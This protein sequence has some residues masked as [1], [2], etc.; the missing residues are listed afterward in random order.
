MTFDWWTFA[1]QAANFLILVWL[2][3]R[4]LF[5]PVTTMVARRK[6][7]IAKA[8][9]DVNAAKANAEQVRKEFETRKAEIEI[10][11][12]KLID[13]EHAVLAKERTQLLAAVRAEAETIKNA[14]VKAL[15]EE[16]TRISNELYAH[17]IDLAVHLAESLLAEL[18]G[19]SLEAPFLSRAID[20]LNR[21]SADQLNSLLG[22]RVRNDVA[23]VV[24]TATP[25]SAQ[26]QIKWRELF[27][28]RLGDH[29]T[30]TFAADAN[31]IAGAEVNFP[32]GVLRHNWR[33]AL[34]V[35][36]SG[37]LGHGQPV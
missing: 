8:I 12:R 6:N 14:G 1:L 26:E 32:Q 22:G 4:Y 17:A 35:L 34:T 2:L 21:L 10:E 20:H 37:M 9:D 7:V 13:D 16:R 28:A 25:L 24:T 15:E 5:K 27:C 30:I 18:A 23:I 31:L 11:R 19:S 29:A 33:D 36:R 3:K